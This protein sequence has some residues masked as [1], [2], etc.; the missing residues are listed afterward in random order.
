MV[1]CVSFVR[2]TDLKIISYSTLV[3]G[4]VYPNFDRVDSVDN[5]FDQLSI[6]KQDKLPDSFFLD[7]RYD[8]VAWRKYHDEN[9]IFY[10]SQERDPTM[11]YYY[12][13]GS[14]GSLSGL[15][16]VLR[17]ID[18]TWLNLTINFLTTLNR[19]LKIKEINES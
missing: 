14:D 12:F 7:G 5:K 13:I 10:H 6:S 1:T 2:H 16:D 17:S 4:D 3:G 11:K 19:N 18:N 15:I 9:Y 8:G